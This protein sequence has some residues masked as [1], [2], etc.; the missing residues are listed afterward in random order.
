MRLFG[1]VVL[2]AA[3]TGAV[4]TAPRA[5]R[6]P[7]APL[8]RC[9]ALA[10]RAMVALG[11]APSDDGSPEQLRQARD[12][13]RSA[14]QADSADAGGARKMSVP[15]T[16]PS[17][18]SLSSTK[19]IVNHARTISERVS[20][21]LTPSFGFSVL[22]A[23]LIALRFQLFAKLGRRYQPLKPVRGALS[24]A[25]TLFAMSRLYT[26]LADTYGL[27]AETDATFRDAIRKAAADA[28]RRAPPEPTRPAPPLPAK[29]PAA[30]MAPK[31]P[32]PRPPP[33]PPPPPPLDIGA[34]RASELRATCLERGVSPSEL[35]A[36]FDRSELEALLLA[37]L[38]PSEPPVA[39][40]SAVDM[41]KAAEMALGMSEAELKEAL[42]AVPGERPRK[43]RGAWPRRAGSSAG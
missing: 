9:A 2:A 28:R 27:T 32:P 14:A 3:G 26:Q 16:L 21:G 25:K 35:S 37:A 5:Q 40:A 41:A 12:A 17:P 4:P 38:A 7:S 29:P 36:V 11:R 23:A 10:P 31:P 20:T 15:M 22:V 43:P 19:R 34:M 24:R 30:V 1:L 6:M 18:N 42:D 8:R 33:P 13:E 39:P